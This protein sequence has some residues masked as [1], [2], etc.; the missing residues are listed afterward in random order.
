MEGDRVIPLR[1]FGRRRVRPI[2]QDQQSECAHACLAM[3]LNHLGGAT[4]LKEMAAITGSGVHGRTVQNIVADARHFGLLGRA[5]RIGIGALPKLRLP[6]ILHWDFNHFVVIEKVGRRRVEI[7]DPA[8]GALSIGYEEVSKHFTGVAIEIEPTGDFQRQRAAPRLR[9]RDILRSI[10]G[11]RGMAAILFGVFFVLNLIGFLIPQVYQ[12]TIDTAVQ[13]GST[14]L[15]PVIFGG[16]FGLIAI[17]VLIGT[18]AGAALVNFRMQASFGIFQRIL[19]RLLFLPSSYFRSRSVGDTVSRMQSFDQIQDLMTSEAIRTTINGLF[20]FFA[21]GIVFLYSKLVLAAVVALFVARLVVIALFYRPIRLRSNLQIVSQARSESKLIEAVRGF[22][23]IKALGAEEMFHD[24]VT[25]AEADNVNAAIRLEKLRLLQSVPERLLDGLDRVLVPGIA[26]YL[27]ADGALTIGMFYAVTLYAR[28]FAEA[29]RE[30]FRFVFAVAEARVHLDRIADIVT[31]E[32]ELAIPEI[33]DGAERAR[34]GADR[35]TGSAEGALE[36]IRSLALEAV[37]FRYA[38]ELPFVVEE[39]DLAVGKGE[40]ICILGPSGGGK[41]T[42]LKL[43]AGFEHP[44]SGRLLVNGAPV[45]ISSLRALRRRLGIVTQED[46]LF[47]GS[48]SDNVIMLPGGADPEGVTRALG[49]AK[50]LEEI[51]QMPMGIDTLL[52]DMGSIIST[53]QRQRIIL[54]RAFY[55][56]PDIFL[57]DEGTAH[58]DPEVTAGIMKEFRGTD[59]G[60]VFVTHAEELADHADRV[61]AL[62]RDGWRQ[63]R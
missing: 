33:G 5:V 60:L 13:Q 48:V 46:E 61:F 50:V 58:L 27:V 26:I 34:D 7:V 36:E 12:F 18:I 29:T 6:A 3:I 21:L 20:G 30:V 40:S 44:S 42:I 51:E 23:S 9:M 49:R 1:F 11:L 43:L 55:R 39:L 41:S 54:A 35:P 25:S 14:A 28:Q 45:R 63:R 10:R 17:Q 56:A 38:G 22:R 53:G 59:A 19:Q 16:L 32:P 24:G 52:G 8:V 57:L 2:L 47:S 37:S 4:D 15:V 31:A 62:D